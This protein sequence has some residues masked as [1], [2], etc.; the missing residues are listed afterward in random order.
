MVSLD[1]WKCVPR[2]GKWKC[3]GFAVVVVHCF[4][5]ADIGV[6]KWKCCC[7]VDCFGIAVVA[8]VAAVVAVVA[9]VDCFGIAVVA[10]AVADVVAAV[11][12]DIRVGAGGEDM[13][14][15]Y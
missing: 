1:Y 6:G 8:V 15:Y 11:I 10:D 3:F 12:A 2:L 13:A 9:V 4:G 14:N 7:C 5:V